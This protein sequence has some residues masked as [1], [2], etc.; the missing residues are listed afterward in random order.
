MDANL[1]VHFA[2]VDDIWVAVKE[3]G[4]D[5]DVLGRAG[6]AHH[7]H[8]A[9]ASVFYSDAAQARL[10]VQDL[11]QLTV[12]RVARVAHLV[13]ER[14]AKALE[15]V[16]K[17]AGTVQ[18]NTRNSPLMPERRVLNLQRNRDDFRWSHAPLPI[19]PY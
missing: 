4:V 8:V 9:R 6:H 15:A 1:L 3:T 17:H 14:Q 7:Q 19:S 13:V 12:V 2:A 18:A 10:V 5:R 16:N 11:L